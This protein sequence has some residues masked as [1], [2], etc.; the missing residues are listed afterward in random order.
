MNTTDATV[1]RE[2]AKRYLDICHHPQQDQRR[3][4]WQK[5][6]SLE[7]VRPLIYVRAFAWR[8]MAESACLCADGLLRECEGF[9]RH[10]LFWDGLADDSIFE[11]W[12]MLR[13]RYESSG[14]GLSG[15]RNLPAESNGAFKIDYPLKE[16]A[17]AEKLRVP[18]H[19]IDEKKTAQD[20]L[21]L[22]EAI[23][24]II[25]VDIDRGPAYRMWSADLSTDLGYLRG[26]E[27][28]MLDIMDNPEWL[29]GLMAFMRDGVLRTH[30]Q[31]EAAG[32]WGLSAHQNQSM[33]YALELQP[34]APNVKGV[35]REALWGFC[36][37]QEWTATS[38][39]Q[40]DE[41][42]LR[43][44]LPLLEPFGLVAYGCCED[45]T[46]KID[47]LRQIPNLRRIAVSPFADVARCAQQIGTDYVIS[48]RPSP[49]DMVGY[50]FD[51]QRIRQILRRDFA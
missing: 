38:P 46:E 37:A 12:V 40:H 19:R 34:P 48:Y 7:P 39:Q 51:P 17:D 4:L 1:L 30:Q 50:D 2:L 21:R 29:H 11:P 22:Q 25:A 45:L 26:I 18:N 33:P 49:A 43:Y 16:L 27:H 47:I 20:A 24:D 44:Q 35:K 9:F 23:G 15:R 42:L 31:A 8:E 41:F 32:D 28:F 14:W 3:D 13:A 6:N 5:K 36:A 10:A